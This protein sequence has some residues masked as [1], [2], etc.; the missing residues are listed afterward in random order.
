[1]CECHFEPFAVQTS[2]G[3]C[4]LQLASDL[5]GPMRDGT[6]TVTMFWRPQT[7]VTTYARRMETSLWRSRLGYKCGELRFKRCHIHHGVLPS[8]QIS[9]CHK[10][11]YLP[12]SSRTLPTAICIMKIS[13]T[14]TKTL[15]SS[16]GRLVH[17]TRTRAPPSFG[18][19]VRSAV[20]LRQFH[21][22]TRAKLMFSDHTRVQ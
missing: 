10:S 12:K 20:N 21:P 6:T 15:S 17:R 4:C 14:C 1:M 7:I 16:F 13:L 19:K 18:M 3:C 5:C 9:P 22:H 11:F 2:A 8:P